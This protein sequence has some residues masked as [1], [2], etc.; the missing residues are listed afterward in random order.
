M[1]DRVKAKFEPQATLDQQIP[2]V[3]LYGPV[4]Q[5]EGDVI[6]C[7]TLFMRLGGCDYRC[8]HCDSMYSVDPSQFKEAPR[9]NAADLGVLV[10]DELRRKGCRMVT[11][12]GGNPLMWDLSGFLAQLPADIEV[13]VE[14][15]G[16]IWRDW[17]SDCR[18]VSL[19]PKGPGM[20]K[21]QVSKDN[22]ESLKAFITRLLVR[23]PSARGI[24]VKVPVFNNGDLSFAERI[25]G[26]LISMPDLGTRDIRR[27]LS[28]GNWAPPLSLASQDSN[29]APS[30]M[31]SPS[32]RRELLVKRYAALCDEVMAHWPSLSRWQVLPQLH[33][34]LFGN[35]RGK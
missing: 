33:V 2:L 26:I 35:E 27:Y 14:T 3:E 32:Q 29:F 12:T 34:W 18:Y 17:L 6:G 24:F 22:L 23:R 8:I 7:Q 19:S 30:G 31:E 25:E 4:I 5:G 11:V 21:D 13:S 16:T 15:Q 20:V 9:Y 10:K 28:L 1:K